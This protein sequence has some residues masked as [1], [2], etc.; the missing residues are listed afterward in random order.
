M[1]GLI[2][3]D[4]V[5]IRVDLSG[6]HIV[7]VLPPH[8]DSAFER[9]KE[10]LL[11]SRFESGREGRTRNVA[12]AARVRLFDSQCR[13]IE[14]WQHRQDGQ[15]VD[16]MAVEDWRARFPKGLKVSI[17]AANFEERET[18]DEDERDDLAPASAGDCDC[19][20]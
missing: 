14:G 13:S 5:R 4:E 19:R 12:S 1:P 15:L 10:E 3:A 7:A 17:V 2:T 8:G 20:S 6:A 18:L 16:A 11:D 9:A